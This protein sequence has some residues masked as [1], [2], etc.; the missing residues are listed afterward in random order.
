[1]VCDGYEGG[2]GMHTRAERHKYGCHGLVNSSQPIEA[3]G[4]PYQMRTLALRKSATFRRRFKQA[5]EALPGI[6][7]D[8]DSEIWKL[9]LIS[10]RTRALLTAL[11]A[12]LHC[13]P[14]QC[15]SFTSALLKTREMLQVLTTNL[16]DDYGKKVDHCRFETHHASL[17]SSDLHQGVTLTLR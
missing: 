12:P 9:V 7:G 16:T 13:I 17:S 15:R 5:G 8:A 6:A 10:S 11:S 2:Q 1:M 14:S 3:T 4:R